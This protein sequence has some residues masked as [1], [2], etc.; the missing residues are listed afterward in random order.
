MGGI[1]YLGASTDGTEEMDGTPCT[2]SA[3]WKPDRLLLFLLLSAL[4]DV[5][6]F[7]KDIFLKCP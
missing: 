2:P 5:F 7:P 4:D 3:K 6:E 1:P